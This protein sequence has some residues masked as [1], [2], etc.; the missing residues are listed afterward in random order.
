MRMYTWKL[1]SDIRVNE[2]YKIKIAVTVFTFNNK[3]NSAQPKVVPTDSVMNVLPTTSYLPINS[4]SIIINSIF[5]L[6]NHDG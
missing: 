1:S 4:Y 6:Q 3:L 5:S 2:Y